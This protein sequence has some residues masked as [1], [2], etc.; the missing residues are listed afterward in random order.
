M[1]RAKAD[2]RVNIKLPQHGWLPVLIT[3][4]TFV[5]EFA[6]SD[7]PNNQIEDLL[8]AIWAAGQGTKALVEWHLEPAYYYFEFIPRQQ[9][10]CLRISYQG[11][12][13]ACSSEICVIH[14]KKQHILLPFWRAL[15]KLET[16]EVA[17]TDWPNV[18]YHSRSRID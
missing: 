12:T 3:Y 2:L 15:R 6:A 4:G 13:E 11:V 18:S 7:V 16:A 1:T 14:G 17:E 10:M 9:D 8:T 5:I